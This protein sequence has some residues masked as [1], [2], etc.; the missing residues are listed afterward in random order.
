MVLDEPASD[1]VGAALRR[2]LIAR[3]D[4][5]HA[6]V[7]SMLMVDAAEIMQAG[8]NLAGGLVLR[9]AARAIRSDAQVAE[10]LK[11]L[12]MG[13]WAR[14]KYRKAVRQEPTHMAD[15]AWYRAMT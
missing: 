3:R 6:L 9:D 1:E 7:I 12:R 14:R 5:A 10:E 13:W 4:G 2:V 11:V 8:G 15:A